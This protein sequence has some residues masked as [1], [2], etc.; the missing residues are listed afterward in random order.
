MVEICGTRCRFIAI[1][2]PLGG[3]LTKKKARVIIVVIWWTACTLALPWALYFE[4][5]TPD[6]DHP[7][8]EF[9]V[10]VW[11]DGIDGDL[12]FLIGNLLLCYLFPLSGISLCYLFIW[13]RVIR[14]DVP[15]TDSMDVLQKV[16]QKAKIGVLKMLIVVVFAFLLSWLPLYTL[17]TRMK[18]GNP[19][20]P[21]EE[22]VVTIARPIAQWLGSSN[23]CVNPIL[24]AFL[25]VK[26]RRAFLSLQPKCCRSRSSTSHVQP[27]STKSSL[28]FTRPHTTSIYNVTTTGV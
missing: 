1:W 9:C 17:F 13:I 15:A 19:L 28:L 8:V 2:F 12:Y 23:S 10:E 6:L 22:S 21:W 11:P 14:R 27:T 3:G 18:F 16:H 24:Y 4:V 7:K 20:S 5:V 26:F 25:N